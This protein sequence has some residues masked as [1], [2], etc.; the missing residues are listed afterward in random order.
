MTSVGT[1]GSHI[2]QI[3]ILPEFQ[4]RCIGTALLHACFERLR[5]RGYRQVS[6]TVTDENSDAIRLYERLG[7][8]TYRRFGAFVWDADK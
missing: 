2:P 4:R 8:R 1:S 7:F 6:L 3:C 5:S